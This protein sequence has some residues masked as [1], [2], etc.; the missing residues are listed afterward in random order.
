MK[1]RNKLITQ[2]MNF[3]SFLAEVYKV[4]EEV[5]DFLKE[6]DE[7]EA[8]AEQFGDTDA[9]GNSQA[10]RRTPQDSAE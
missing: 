6:H 8:S 2:D 10:I 7:K 3:D 9:R 5:D 4:N 1:I